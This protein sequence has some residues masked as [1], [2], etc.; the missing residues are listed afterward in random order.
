MGVVLV[1]ITAVMHHGVIIKHGEEFSCELKHAKNLVA[2]GSAKLKEQKQN[3]PDP[4]EELKKAFM[5]L[6]SDELKTLADENKVELAPEDTT[7][8][9]IVEKLIAAGLRI[10]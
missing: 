3:V 4:L 5:V 9:Q 7:K 6:K 1:A 8:T 10:G 2:G